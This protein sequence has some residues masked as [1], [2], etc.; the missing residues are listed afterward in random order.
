MARIQR[1]L[2]VNTTR[3]PVHIFPTMDLLGRTVPP[4]QPWTM[5]SPDG[6]F[7][8]YFPI[9]EYIPPDSVDSLPTYARTISD[10]SLRCTSCAICGEWIYM[11]R[12]RAFAQHHTTRTIRSDS[13]AIR[14]TGIED[15][16]P[17]ARNVCPYELCW[18][19]NCVEGIPL[20]FLED[21]QERTAHWCHFGCMALRLFISA[22]SPNSF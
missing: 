17:G 9:V 3:F 15:I 8:R 12:L 19:F 14:A 6:R 16:M 22:V 20:F 4:S 7:R 18:P 2:S 21:M 10:V 11:D 1:R 13:M 5:S